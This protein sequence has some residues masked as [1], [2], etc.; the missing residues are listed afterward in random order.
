M[1]LWDTTM[2]IELPKSCAIDCRVRLAD[3]RCSKILT[4]FKASSS[5]ARGDKESNSSTDAPLIAF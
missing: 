5:Q 1:N 2:Q 4:L 3:V